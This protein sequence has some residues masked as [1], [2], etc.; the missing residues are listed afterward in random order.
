MNSIVF[1][2]YGL[3]ETN[4][5]IFSITFENL[6][7]APNKFFYIHDIDIKIYINDGVQDRLH[8]NQVN[9]K[10]YVPSEDLNNWE[11]YKGLKTCSFKINKEL[12]KEI[13]KYWDN[14]FVESIYIIFKTDYDSIDII[15]KLETQDNSLFTI[16]RNG[17]D[18]FA[19]YAKD[20]DLFRKW[21]V[22]MPRVFGSNSRK[23]K[24][25]ERLQGQGGQNLGPKPAK[26]FDVITPRQ[27]QRITSS[28]A[29][30]RLQAFDEDLVQTENGSYTI[31]YDSNVIFFNSNPVNV[32]LNQSV[33]VYWKNFAYT[34]GISFS[35]FEIILLNTNVKRTVR[36][37]KG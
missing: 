13:I 32:P 35:E 30:V 17:S 3:N 15:Q 36:I 18:T 29:I 16:G 22:N 21:Q 20:Y 1:F 33:T 24:I 26:T 2:Q 12:S 11:K 8:K 23:P 28:G 34:G 14:I 27:N 10:G 4:E 6:M 9:I 25:I 19:L 31:N 7:I 5:L 37:L